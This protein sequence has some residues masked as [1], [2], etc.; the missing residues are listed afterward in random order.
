MAVSTQQECTQ[1]RGDPQSELMPESKRLEQQEGTLCDRREY[2]VVWPRA[3]ESSM[4]IRGRE[5]GGFQKDFNE[6]GKAL[7]KTEPTGDKVP[8][9][10]FWALL[11]G[12]PEMTKGTGNNEP[13]LALPKGG[14]H[15]LVFSWPG[16]ARG[17]CAL[18]PFSPCSVALWVERR[19]F[20]PEHSGSRTQTSSK[21][22]S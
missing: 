6:G 2:M 14:S 18:P 17:L 15:C 12:W 5:L 22:H 13:G 7:P 8:T 9:E 10:G 1:H 3:Q 20:S 21:G 16:T 11:T 4:K 19:S